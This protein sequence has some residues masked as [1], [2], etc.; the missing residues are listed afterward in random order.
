MFGG[1]YLQRFAWFVLIDYGTDP[2]AKAAISTGAFINYRIQESLVILQHDYAMPDTNRS[3]GMASATVLIVGDTYHFTR[4]STRCSIM[5][6][7]LSQQKSHTSILI[8]STMIDTKNISNNNNRVTIQYVQTDN[9]LC[10]QTNISLKCHNVLGLTCI[11]KT[12]KQLLPHQFINL[13]FCI[14]ILLNASKR[15]KAPVIVVGLMYDQ[16]L[17]GTCL[18]VK[19]GTANDTPVTNNVIEKYIKMSV[20]ADNI[21]H[22]GV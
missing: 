19:N 20:F 1:I 16:K 21:D 12:A 6:K 22:L 13:F 9:V 7:Y 8:L 17:R 14:F 15:N 10:S 3:T 2:L 5:L 11:R 18:P 4:F